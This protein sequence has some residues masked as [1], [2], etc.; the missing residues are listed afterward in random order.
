M[1][2]IEFGRSPL[3]GKHTDALPVPPACIV[4]RKFKKKNKRRKKGKTLSLEPPKRSRQKRKRSSV[5][6]SILVKR[7]YKAETGVNSDRRN[8]YLFN[9]RRKKGG[10]GRREACEKGGDSRGKKLSME[11]CERVF[12][13]ARREDV[14]KRNGENRKNKKKKKM[15]YWERNLWNRLDGGTVDHEKISALLTKRSLFSLC[16]TAG[17]DPGRSLYKQKRETF[18]KQKKMN[19]RCEWI[20]HEASIVVVPSS[21]PFAYKNTYPPSR[22]FG[23]AA[24]QD[25]ARMFRFHA[26]KI[27]RQRCRKRMCKKENRKYVE[28]LSSE[29]QPFDTAITYNY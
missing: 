16:Q 21:F 14:K 12:H 19:V 1:V 23:E 13:S 25:F 27:D 10:Y 9:A 20:F 2:S 26:N 18:K 4:R 22:F 11:L 24:G 17:Q 29:P 5:R 6:N 3:L 8:R 7:G 15:W 28:S